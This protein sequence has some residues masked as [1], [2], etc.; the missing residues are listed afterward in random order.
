MAVVKY[1]TN[2]YV[3]T[4]ESSPTWLQFWIAY[5]YSNGVSINMKYTQPS[6]TWQ[7]LLTKC[8]IGACSV[9]TPICYR[10]QHTHQHHYLP[11]QP[12]PVRCC[13]VDGAT[14][15]L[16]QGNFQDTPRD[17]ARSLTIPLVYQ[18]PTLCCIITDLPLCGWLLIIQ[19]HPRVQVQDFTKLA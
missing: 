18:W 1:V 16:Q 14:Y 15:T 7:R 11:N 17:H 3:W 19:D 6:W 9:S 8:P 2:I 12:H 5:D 10:Q 13:V 4:V